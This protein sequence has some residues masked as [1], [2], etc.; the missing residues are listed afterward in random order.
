MEFL[1]CMLHSTIQTCKNH[2]II[3]L[4]SSPIFFNSLKHS[5]VMPFQISRP[6][7]MKASHFLPSPSSKLTIQLEIGYLMVLGSTRGTQRLQTPL[8]INPWTPHDAVISDK[9][10][11]QH[12]A[13]TAP[14]RNNS[15]S[16]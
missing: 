12:L 11:F 13:H 7:I 8:T 2:S 3:C 14:V 4:A 16:S 1:L 6:R 5:S 10:S 15:S 9:H